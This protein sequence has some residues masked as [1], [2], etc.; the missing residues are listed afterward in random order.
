MQ[1]PVEKP[2][3]F[4]KNLSTKGKSYPLTHVEAVI[5]NNG[6]SLSKTLD[7]IKDTIPSVDASSGVLSCIDNEGNNHYIASTDDPSGI[8]KVETPLVSISGGN[9]ETQLNPNTIYLIGSSSNNCT[10]LAITLNSG[11]SNVANI[12]HAIVVT[13]NDMTFTKPDTIIIGNNEELPEFVSNG[14]FEF[15]ILENLMYFSY[16][17]PESE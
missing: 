2:I 3:K 17:V 7:E 8:V 12:Y 15:N 5:N 16:T 10:S 9:V 13:D 11:N 14:I 1:K 6:D 4:V